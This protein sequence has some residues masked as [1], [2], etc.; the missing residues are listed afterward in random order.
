[1]QQQI[2]SPRPLTS[3]AVI[4]SL[5]VGGG[6]LLT[7]ALMSVIA[8][9][10]ALV[11]TEFGADVCHGRGR[12]FESRRPR[13]FKHLEKWRHSGVGTKRY[14]KGSNSKAGNRVHY[15][16]DSHPRLSDARSFW[17]FRPP[18]SSSYW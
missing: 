4:R 7:A 8:V 9:I 17:L 5:I 10:S 15:V 13:H 2:H 18:F 3:Q 1:M 14:Q 16:S 11:F 12:G 6:G